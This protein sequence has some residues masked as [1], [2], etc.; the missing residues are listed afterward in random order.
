MH[1]AQRAGYTIYL[2]KTRGMGY[3]YTLIAYRA[4]ERDALRS[5]P[6]DLATALSVTFVRKRNP[7]PVILR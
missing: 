2:I 6:D 7:F 3:H 1:A 5:L 4:N